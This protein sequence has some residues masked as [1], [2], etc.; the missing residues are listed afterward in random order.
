MI[1]QFRL[2]TAYV[3]SLSIFMTAIFALLLSIQNVMA[4]KAP[5]NLCDHSGPTYQRLVSWLH[6]RFGPGSSAADLRNVFASTPEY[7]VNEE[8]RAVR[9]LNV[10]GS[11]EQGNVRLDEASPYSDTEA[12]ISGGY[13]ACDRDDG[14]ADHWQLLIHE[15]EHGKIIEFELALFYVD[16]PSSKGRN[17]PLN[18][19]RFNGFN[20]TQIPSIRHRSQAL[21]D[22]AS[23]LFIEM[24]EGGFLREEIAGPQ[25]PTYATRRRE[26][27]LKKQPN[28]VRAF[29][30]P[31]GTPVKET[32]KA[33]LYLRI[34]AYATS[35]SW[36]VVVIEYEGESDKV[37]TIEAFQTF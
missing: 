34:G 19:D 20:K 28:L 10:L 17:E 21:G 12:L 16:S 26:F 2:R 7:E 25:D 37:L 6:D 13:A 27:A 32:D 8:A 14:Q 30:I 33:T 29:M 15:D 9:L 22:S 18:G 5:I 23:R 11:L 36:P 24:E 1:I 3:R 31:M 4:F 35:A